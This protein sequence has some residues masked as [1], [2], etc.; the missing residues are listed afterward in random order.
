MIKP[1]NQSGKAR[2]IAASPKPL[3]ILDQ[4]R[5]GWIEKSA[6]GQG[7]HGQARS[8]SLSAIPGVWKYCQ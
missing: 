5:R 4:Q 7:S 6:A 8:N 2:S 1:V 3:A